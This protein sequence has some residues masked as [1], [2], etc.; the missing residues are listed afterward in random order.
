MPSSVFDRLQQR[1]DNQQTRPDVTA[2]SALSKIEQQ[3]IGALIQHEDAGH[4][5]INAETLNARLPSIGGLWDVVANLVKNGWLTTQEPGPTYQ[6]NPAT[7]SREGRQS[8][9]AMLA[10]R[11]NDRDSH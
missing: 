6:L 10:A 7:F 2:F 1:I 3:I 8:I 5:G 9:W 4:A 11:M